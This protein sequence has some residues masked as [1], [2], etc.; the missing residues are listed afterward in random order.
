[1]A[2]GTIQFVAAPSHLARRV[3]LSTASIGLGPC[4][5]D[6]SGDLGSGGGGGGGRHGDEASGCEDKLCCGRW[7]RVGRSL[8]LPGSL[9]LLLLLLQGSVLQV[10]V[11]ERLL[12]RL[13]LLLGNHQP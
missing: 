3:S 9:L 13:A 11:L 7:L 2:A 12:H 1:M 10:H 5:L 4:G 8:P 6:P